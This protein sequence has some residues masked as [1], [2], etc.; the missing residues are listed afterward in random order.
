MSNEDELLS[1][2]EQIVTNAVDQERSEYTEYVASV[3][4]TVE[5]RLYEEYGAEDSYRVF[6]LNM[7]FR[8]SA[9]SLKDWRI[10]KEMEEPNAESIN[11]TENAQDVN[12][13]LEMENV[14]DGNQDDMPDS[15]YTVLEDRAAGLY[16]SSQRSNLVGSVV[17]TG[18]WTSPTAKDKGI[19]PSDCPD[20]ES[21]TVTIYHAGSFMVA[22]S[23]DDKSGE[24]IG[25]SQVYHVFEPNKDCDNKYPGNNV[26]IADKCIEWL[27]DTHG[28]LPSAI[29]GLWV[30][31]QAIKTDD[32]EM[33]DALIKDVLLAKAK[34]NN[35]NN[36]PQK[37]GSNDN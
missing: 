26:Q 7:A 16:L 14:W 11:I 35:N 20:R 6:S 29:Y 1:E 22:L 27:N 18:A 32:P 23:R 17:R 3:A 21:V 28:R 2:V 25:D 15:V 33:Y 10:T 19:K 37:E 13:C 12:S 34:G 36:N 4:K 8:G 30:V 5:K 24:L 31:P 9:E